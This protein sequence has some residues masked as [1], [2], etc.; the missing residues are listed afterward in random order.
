MPHKNNLPNGSKRGKW[1]VVESFTADRRF[2]L[3][4]CECG[5]EKAV[6]RGLIADGRSTQCAKCAS[7]KHGKTSTRLYGVWEAMRG[8]CN[9]PNDK[10]Y[11]NYGGRG[12]TVC[13]RWDSFV[14]F[15]VDMGEPAPG[16][17]LDRENNDL[18]YSPENCRWATSH[19]Q[20][21]NRRKIAGSSQ[22]RGVSLVKWGNGKWRAGF[23]YHYKQKCIGH[24]DDEV[25]AARAYDAAVGPLG[26]PT[27]FQGEA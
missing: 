22:F 21:I 5:T 15:L 25:S 17:T 24:F 26:Y 6:S 14:N 16:T 8:R 1:T 27:N 7:F 20:V 2:A 10:G 9:N 3:V 11:K 13:E 12:I 23:T 18:G 19:E 4:R